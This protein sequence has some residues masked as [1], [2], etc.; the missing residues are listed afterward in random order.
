MATTKKPVS[1]EQSLNDL[2]QLVTQ[3]ETGELSLDDSL[4]A[5]ENGVKLTRECQSILDDAE[6]KVQILSEQNGEI[7]SAPFEEK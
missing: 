6:Q 5:F 4:K 3:M 1:F 2:E 7:V